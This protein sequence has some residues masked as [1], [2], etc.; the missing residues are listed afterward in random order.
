MN[1]DETIGGMHTRF[2]NIVNSLNNLGREIKTLDVVLKILRSL[3][4]SWEP[5]RIAIEEAQDLQ[6]LTLE[7]LIG[8]LLSYEVEKQKLIQESRKGKKHSLESF[9]RRQ[10]RK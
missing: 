8:S 10:R 3:P 5:K 2:T 4:R 7:E 9:K 1:S 6:R